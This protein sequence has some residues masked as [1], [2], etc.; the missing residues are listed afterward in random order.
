MDRMTET[1]RILMRGGDNF[2]F[3]GRVIRRATVTDH[4]IGLRMRDIRRDRGMT[5]LE[6]GRV[7]HSSRSTISRLE[8]GSVRFKPD[9]LE[10]IARALNVSR[11]YLETGVEDA[12]GLRR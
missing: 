9:A 12:P 4:D 8:N 3:V 10:R 11:S 7:T 2:E 5:Q 6:L 1:G